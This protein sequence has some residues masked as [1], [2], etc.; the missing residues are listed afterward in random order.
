MSIK[1]HEAFKMMAFLGPLA[2]IA[3]YIRYSVRET[4]DPL[5]IVLLIVGG[6]LTLAALIFNLG[7]IRESSRRRST[8]LGANTTVMTV[9]VVAI[10]GFGNFLGYRHHKRIDMTTE[11]LYSLSDQTRKVVSD[12][13]KDVRVILFDK[14]DQQGLG[15]QMKEYR[16]LSSRFTF[17]RIDPQKNMETAKKYEITKLGD[18][19]VVS[20]DRSERPKDNTEQA[21]INA[22]IKV[23]RDSLKKV[24][25]VEGH[26]EKKLSS[27]DEG[28]GY[29][30]I[31]KM[32]KDENYEVKSIN[33][34]ASNDV[35]SD[36][37]VL[38]LAGPKQSLFPQEA[39]AIGKYLE[40]GGKAMLLID[41]DTDP[42]LDDVLSAWGMQLGKNTV[43]DVSGVGRFF[44]LGPG[45]PLVRTYGSHAITK[46]F[47]VTMTFFP[48]SRSVETT[49]GGSAIDLMKTTE[50]SWAETELT[51]DKVAFDEGK[52][53]KGPITLGLAASKT[54]GEAEARLVLI[55]DSDFAANQFV[56]VQRNGDLFMNSINWLAQDEDLISIRPKSAADRKV[57]MTEADQ[58]QLFWITL[59]LMPLAT[60]GSG[61]YIWWKRR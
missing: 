15:D 36:C 56:G 16:N 40:K 5:N 34:V 44:N 27:T 19:V 57:S 4:M 50:E 58:N 46:D 41:P 35:P 26:G 48:M 11:K 1:R 60:I 53:K 33:L 20:G 37:D 51:S 30:V 2:L 45:A 7:A 3:G 54:E 43:V 52:D 9:A 24:C 22:I 17:E 21:I 23:T 8:K 13:K 29:G 28:D 59:V 61:L 31:D 10:I 12:L 18:V 49:G 47:G 6:L 42:K 25:F 38:V 14:D 32:L 55:G 39:S